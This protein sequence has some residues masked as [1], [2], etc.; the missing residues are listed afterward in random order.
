MLPVP[1]FRGIKRLRIHPARLFQIFIMSDFIGFCTGARPDPDVSCV[2]PSGPMESFHSQPEVK[3]PPG[4]RIAGIPAPYVISRISRRKPISS[5][6]GWRGFGCPVNPAAN[7][8]PESNRTSVSAYLTH[9]I[10]RC[11]VIFAF[12]ILFLSAA[13]MFILQFYQPLSPL[14][15]WPS[16]KYFCPNM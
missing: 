15:A 3:L 14:V 2:L 11:I 6:R 16:T 4:I 9:S 1:I 13:F 8:A 10:I 12:C 7:R 5:A